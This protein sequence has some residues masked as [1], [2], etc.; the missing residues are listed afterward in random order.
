MNN[1]SNQFILYFRLFTFSSSEEIRSTII[2]LLRLP[3]DK[4]LLSLSNE[5]EQALD[6]LLSMFQEDQWI[7]Q[8]INK[9]LFLYQDTRSL[10]INIYLYP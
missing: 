3:L 4:R 5:V 8:V 7:E 1:Y 9:F 2:V 6:S 10:N